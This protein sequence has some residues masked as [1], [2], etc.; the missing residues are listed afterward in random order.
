MFQKTK[1][2]IESM[3]INKEILEDSELQGS[4]G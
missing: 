3:H 1:S 4:F 2:K